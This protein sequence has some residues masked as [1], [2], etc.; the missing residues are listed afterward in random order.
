MAGLLE[1]PD[2]EPILSGVPTP[3][4]WRLLNANFRLGDRVHATRV[5]AIAGSSSI[6]PKIRDEA[7]SCLAL[8]GDPSQFDRVTWHHLPLPER[9]VPWMRELVRPIAMDWIR[10][11]KRP[12]AEVSERFQNAI[13]KLITETG[14]LKDTEV[15]PLLTG[16][17]I[18]VP[19]KR[20]L[21][22]TMT[23]SDLASETAITSLLENPDAELRA[24]AAA[25]LAR[26][27]LP[28]GWN[29]IEAI[30][31]RGDISAKQR[32]I[33]HI[34]LSES[35]RA[36][37]ILL[38]LIERYEEDELPDALSLD[39]IE[40]GR[41]TKHVAVKTRLQKIRERLDEN[42]P[43]G[44]NVLA[45]TG[46]NQKEGRR[47]FEQHAAQ[48]IRCHRINE[49]G[50]QAGPDL[51]H[52]GSQIPDREILE[53]M[54]D[55]QA[56]IAPDYGMTQITLTDGELIEGSILDDAPNKIRLRLAD[57][58]EVQL[59][60]EKIATIAPAASGMPPMG[61]L[62]TPLELRDLTAYLSS[63]K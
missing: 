13:L 41:R 31:E 45:L 58:S 50:G 34:S 19:I 37:K 21:L 15:L 14:C 39:L 17:K 4:A 59:D 60:R 27:D 12:N 44:A 40:H 53:A 63:L 54:L 10:S 11:L 49:F 43:L 1:G 61:E 5:A 26:A 25:A 6:D 33:E 22:T 55:P 62:L 48:C 42:E 2:A 29:A 28:H 52:I 24:D 47:V 56:R 18:P 35:S 36:G 57:G 7:M 23:P 46:G 9:S 20:T 8:W 3:V 30:L 32:V 16:A 51:S 38:E